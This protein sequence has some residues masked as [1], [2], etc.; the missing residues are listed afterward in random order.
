VEKERGNCLVDDTIEKTIP[1]EVF[2]IDI[3][4]EVLN[5]SSIS[6]SEIRDQDWRL[7]ARYFNVEGKHA[8]ELLHKCKWPVVN[9][10]SENGFAKNAQYPGR[11][12]RIYV[13]TDGIPCRFSGY[14]TTPSQVNVPP[15][16]SG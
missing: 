14:M 8:R 11:F 15:C 16:F 3:P 12:K 4:E 6:L 13:E 7:E 5:W 2:V 10:W 9:L 1:Q